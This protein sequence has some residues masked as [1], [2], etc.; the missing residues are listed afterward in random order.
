MLKTRVGDKVRPPGQRPLGPPRLNEVQPRTYGAKPET[1]QTLVG[2][3]GTGAEGW[4][5]GER[6]RKEGD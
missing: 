4:G 3:W 5:E 2:T 1:G 6:W